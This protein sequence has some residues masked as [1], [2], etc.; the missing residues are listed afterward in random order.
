MNRGNVKTRSALYEGRGNYGATLGRLK[1]PDHADYPVGVARQSGKAPA[2]ANESKCAEHDRFRRWNGPHRSLSLGPP[3]KIERVQGTDPG[4]GP[5][6]Q[7][8]FPR[9]AQ[10][11]SARGTEESNDQPDQAYG[12]KKNTL[13]PLRRQQRN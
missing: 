1:G 10:Q 6:D 9:L 7:Q 13:T 4:H 5:D 11:F 12:A 3:V 2:A 8:L